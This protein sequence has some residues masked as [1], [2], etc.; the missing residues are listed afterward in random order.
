MSSGWEELIVSI[1]RRGFLKRAG[2]TGGAVAAAAA[3]PGCHTIFPPGYTPRT[4]PMLSLAASDSKVDTIVV[5]MMENRS[6][7]HYLGWLGTDQ[8]YLDDGRRRFGRYFGINASN[9]QTYSG[10]QGE[11]EPTHHMI[12][13]DYL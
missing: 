13:W 6:F 12:G 1:D 8:K 10:P 3:L 5:V 7:D 11:P 9:Q 2:L 4:D